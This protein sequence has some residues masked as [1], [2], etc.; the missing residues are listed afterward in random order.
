VLRWFTRSYF[1]RVPDDTTLLR[2]AHTL[3]PATLQA[4]LDRVAL[5]ARAGTGAPRAPAAG[6]RHRGRDGDPLSNR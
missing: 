4:L 2:W 5:L 3:R 6:G 1:R